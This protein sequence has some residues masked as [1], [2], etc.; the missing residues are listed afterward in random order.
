MG[1]SVCTS[2]LSTA[3]RLPSIF[4][5]DY[6]LRSLQARLDFLEGFSLCNCFLSFILKV[7][8]VNLFWF[9]CPL[10]IPPPPPPN[11]EFIQLRNKLNQEQNAKLQQQRECLNKRNSEVAVMDKRVNELRERLWKKKAA[12]QQKENVPVSAGCFN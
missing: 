9:C 6:N 1:F 5:G 4:S 12:L 10:P 2:S 11:N 8:L 7:N 3:W